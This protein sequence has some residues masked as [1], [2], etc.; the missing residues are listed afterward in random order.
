MDLQSIRPTNQ[1]VPGKYGASWYPMLPGS[2]SSNISSGRHC[3]C[4]ASI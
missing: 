3:H 2:S 4:V 1:L